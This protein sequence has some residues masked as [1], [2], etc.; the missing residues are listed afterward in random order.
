MIP[1][2]QK[3]YDKIHCG[4]RL[5]NFWADISNVSEEID[6]YMPLIFVHSING[7]PYSFLPTDLWIEMAM[8]KG[9][10]MKAGWQ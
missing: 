2:L 3:I 7:K 6:Q 4:Q 9:S 10:K 5:P 1:W 8:K